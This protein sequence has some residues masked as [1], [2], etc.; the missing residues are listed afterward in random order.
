[1][2]PLTICKISEEEIV[3]DD[4]LRELT[5]KTTGAVVFFTG[6]VRGETERNDPRETRYLEYE[7]YQSMAEQKMQ[8]ISDDIRN[9]WNTVQSI[10]M[11]QKIGKLL[12]GNIAVV[13]A[14]SA[15]HRDTGVFE[16][17]RYGIDRL[18][19]IVPVWKKEVGT[20]GEA[21]VEGDF[22]PPTGE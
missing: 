13:I 14:C 12:P 10:I 19:E 17:A 1:M 15:P 20:N 8:L 21:W 18:K 11:I 9:K 16:A 7:A 22:I 4:I 3:L 5:S 6:I 2:K